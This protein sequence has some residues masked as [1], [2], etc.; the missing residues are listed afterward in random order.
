MYL[1]FIGP[2]PT[3]GASRVRNCDY[4]I[5]QTAF[6]ARDDQLMEQCLIDEL[7]AEVDWFKEHLPS[8]DDHHF[9]YAGANV[10]ICWFRDD[11]RTMIRRCRR[12]VNILC[13]GDIWVTEARTDNPGQILY[14]D[15]YQIVAKP[16][17][18]TPTKWGQ[19][20][21]SLRR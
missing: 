7:M 13:A 9:D 21:S 8:P 1:R 14:R 3:R 12:M 10:G 15:D 20:Q 4:G 17:K 5:F 6:M 16:R 19:H 11:A 2:F 18:S